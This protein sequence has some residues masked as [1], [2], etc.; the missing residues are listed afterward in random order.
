MW[1]CSLCDG[2]PWVEVCLLWWCDNVPCVV[3]WLGL[4]RVLFRGV[5]GVV[6]CLVWFCSL[7]GGVPRVE[8]CIL[9]WCAWCDDLPCVVV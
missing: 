8:V 1:F 5:L 9:W 6:T 4:M 7:Y 2:V 3:V